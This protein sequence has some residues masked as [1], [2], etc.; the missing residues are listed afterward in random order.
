VCYHKQ[1]YKNVSGLP[2]RA[3]K[4]LK[5][6]IN[7]ENSAPNSATKETV[8]EELFKMPVILMSKIEREHSKNQSYQSNP[9]F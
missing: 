5:K 7:Q 1:D 6:K 4:M 8:E 9:L 3:P 2:P